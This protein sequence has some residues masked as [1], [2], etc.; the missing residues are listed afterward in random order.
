MPIALFKMNVKSI[1]KKSTP[2]HTLLKDAVDFVASEIEWPADV[3][4]VGPPTGGDNSDVELI[5]DE[6]LTENNILPTEVAGEI[7]VI[8]W[9]RRRERSWSLTTQKQEQ[10]KNEA[11]PEWKKFLPV[12]NNENIRTNEEDNIYAS[13]RLHEEFPEVHNGTE[14]S[15]FQLVFDHIIDLLVHN[16]NLYVSGD[17]MI[18]KFNVSQDETRTFLDCYYFLVITTVAMQMI[19]GELLLIFLHPFLPKQWAGKDLEISNA[20]FMFVITW[21]LVQ[22]KWPKLYQ[23][24]M[25]W[26][27]RYSPLVFSTAN[28]VLM[29]QWSHTSESR[30]AN[31]LYVE[32]LFDLGINVWC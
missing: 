14:C 32:N 17:K 9:R 28:S 15:V 29:S 30:V 10:K 20:I 3:V 22:R 8:F 31:S 7:E 21:I 16:T 11:N 4:I 12:R 13:T 24:M 27:V 2:K 5:D 26:I 6:D 25:C 23:P 18:T 1:Y 19:I